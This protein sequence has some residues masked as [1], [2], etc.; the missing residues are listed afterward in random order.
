MTVQRGE[1]GGWGVIIEADQVLG[2]RIMGRIK[3]NSSVIRAQARGGRSGKICVEEDSLRSRKK[4]LRD[5]KG[6]LVGRDGMRKVEEGEGK[7]KRK[8]RKE[9]GVMIR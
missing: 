1:E 3:E 9:G 4:I 6:C 5:K 7:G 2:I 8:G